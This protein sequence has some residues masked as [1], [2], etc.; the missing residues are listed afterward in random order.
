MKKW[1]QKLAREVKET[2]NLEPKFPAGQG[3]RLGGGE[4]GPSQPSGPAAA[5]RPLD[6]KTNAT[7]TASPPISPYEAILR[8][9]N[10][11]TCAAALRTMLAGVDDDKRKREEIQES[12]RVLR[13]I[14][15]NV[16]GDPDNDKVRT[17]RLANAKIDRFVT[18]PPGARALLLGCGFTEIRVDDAV[19]S[20]CLVISRDLA[21]EKASLMRRV[22]RVIENLLGIKPEQQNVTEPAAVTSTSNPPE[23]SP[24]IV[25]A[26]V[27]GNGGRNTMLELPS[28]VE[29]ANLPPEFYEQSLSEVQQLYRHNQEALAQS[30]ILM[31]KAQ[32]EKLRNKGVS[33]VEKSSVRVRVR[34]PE[35]V[36]IVGDFDRDE[37]LQALFSWVAECLNEQF[38]EF[39]L[40][41]PPPERRSIG[42]L[43]FDCSRTIR[44]V[45]GGGDVTLNLIIIGGEVGDRGVQ[46]VGPTFKLELPR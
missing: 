39:D 41:T 40:I 43:R 17:L 37:P 19:E 35:A 12:M 2:F 1:T 20:A 32:R 38:L 16:A 26:G 15:S 44:D 5:R 18:K 8:S 27:T 6:S 31:T 23:S 14:L 22:V 25:K 7:K 29:D 24:P 4:P 42:D 10:D 11:D 3:R 9:I 30:K 28:A 46:R 34:A 21:R 33:R 13:K 45:F 36:K